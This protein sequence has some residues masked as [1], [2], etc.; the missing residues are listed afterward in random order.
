MLCSGT[1]CYGR[2]VDVD[3]NVVEGVA[4]DVAVDEMV[5]RCRSGWSCRCRCR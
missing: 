2:P 5:G 1:A 4:V 3:V